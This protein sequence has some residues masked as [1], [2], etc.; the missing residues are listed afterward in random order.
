MPADEQDVRELPAYGVAEAAHYLL[1]PRATL[2]AW[3]AGMSYSSDGERRFFKPVIQP[4]ATSPVAL[5][6][7]NLVEAHV[8]AAIR[9]KHRVD[10]PAV[11]RTIYFLKKEFRSPHP[12]ADHKFETN[13]VDL[14]IEHLGDFISASQGGQLAMRDLLKARLRRIDRDDKGFPLRL[15]PFTRVDGTDQPKN[16]VI[17][18]F[19]SFGKAVITGTGV[20]T[21]IVAERFKAGESADE[22]ANDYGCD[23]EKIE[24]AIRCEL[25]LAEAA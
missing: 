17:D 4:A 12:L 16:V 20:S 9:R 2:R 3:V 14:F 22:L 6:F 8:L 11:R 23:R 7:I 1:V 18:L 10:M 25:S 21:E 5:S 24:E 19:I 15:Y 13:G